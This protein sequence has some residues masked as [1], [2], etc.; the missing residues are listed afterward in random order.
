[1]DSAVQGAV[2]AVA[3]AVI[4][5]KKK[6]KSTRKKRTIWVKPWLQRRHLLGAYDTLLN[7]FRQE[8]HL[9]Y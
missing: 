4:V 9:E 1:M 7:E 2:I 3:V 5:K 8:D 6:K